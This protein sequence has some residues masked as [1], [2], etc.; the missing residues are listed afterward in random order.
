MI[1]FPVLFASRLLLRQLEETDDKA[2]FS[3]RSDDRVNRF[4]DRKKPTAIEE[5]STFIHQINASIAENNSL[6]WAITLKEKHTLIGTICLWNYSP[7]RKTAEL[8]YE[9]SPEQQGKGLMQEALQAVTR[10]AFEKAGFTTLEAYTH[11]D[12]LASTRLLLKQG[13][14]Y[15]PDRVE[16]ENENHVI[17]ALSNSQQH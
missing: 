3:L 13:F 16:N 7:D 17:Y 2:I 5:A 11:K 10:Y 4:L 8:G 12:N 9:L 1:P 14:T 6:Y 15:M